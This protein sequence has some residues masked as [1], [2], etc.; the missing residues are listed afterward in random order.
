ME[1]QHFSYV[2]FFSE[3]HEEE[4]KNTRTA[5]DGI[6]NYGAHEAHGDYYNSIDEAVCQFIHAMAS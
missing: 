2:T 6:E 5:H 4:H 3:T 1:W